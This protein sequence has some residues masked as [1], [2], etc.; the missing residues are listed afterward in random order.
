MR[1]GKNVPPPCSR[2]HNQLPLH[3]TVPPRY[4]RPLQNTHD[5]PVFLYNSCWLLT[6]VVSRGKQERLG[7]NG[8]SAAWVVTHWGQG[9][10]CRR[11]AS[12]EKAVL[13]YKPVHHSHARSPACKETGNFGRWGNHSNYGNLETCFLGSM[14]ISCFWKVS[15]GRANL[16]KSQKKLS[17]SGRLYFFLYPSLSGS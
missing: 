4:L 1:T 2:L 8:R 6:S 17:S 12:E 10:L 7:T 3:I 15:E 16:Y 14:K 5:H 9:R 13:F 11:G